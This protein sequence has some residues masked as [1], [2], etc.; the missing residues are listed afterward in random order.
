M[1]GRFCTSALLVIAVGLD[2]RCLSLSLETRVNHMAARSNLYPVL[3]LI[4]L[5]NPLLAIFD[6][7]ECG[8]RSRGCVYGFS[9]LTTPRSALP[10]SPQ[11][12]LLR[13]PKPWS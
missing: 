12:P 8:L 5:S 3:A 11:H 4:L 10:F 9:R 1:A 13:P 6:I 2:R 7:H